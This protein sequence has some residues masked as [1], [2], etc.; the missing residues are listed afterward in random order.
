MPTDAS[1]GPD[2]CL[3]PIG[4]CDVEECEGGY[5]L[6][7]P[8]DE[9]PAH[10]DEPWF[11]NYRAR[12]RTQLKTAWVETE[13]LADIFEVQLRNI[14]ECL[15]CWLWTGELNTV[16]ALARIALRTRELAVQCDYEDL[17]GPNW[18]ALRESRM[19]AGELMGLHHN[20]DCAGKRD[21]MQMGAKLAH[22]VGYVCDEMLSP[23]DPHV[24]GG[25]KGAERRWKDRPDTW[26]KWQDG[27]EEHMRKHPGHGAYTRACTHLANGYGVSPDT[28]RKNTKNPGI[29]QTCGR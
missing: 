12:V 10:R 5:V 8:R 22:L 26:L 23:I 15:R 7:P 20:P 27:V 6:G 1:P 16:Q 28:I 17:D 11:Q 19:L 13:E 18:R 14:R 21:L 3:I 2:D 29:T 25:V 9:F 24:E 4:F